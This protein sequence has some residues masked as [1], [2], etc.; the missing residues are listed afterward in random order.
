MY[1]FPQLL[2]KNL[3][4]SLIFI[5]F[6]GGIS[7][8]M[9]SSLLEDKA[10]YHSQMINLLTQKIE[11]TNNDDNTAQN[12]AKTLRK[13]TNYDSLVISNQ[14]GDNL[15]SYINNNKE[16]T[17]PYISPKPKKYIAKQLGVNIFY[18]L[19]FSNEYTLVFNLILF[20]LICSFF[21]VILA[22]KM[23]TKRHEAVFKL[24]NQQIKTDLAL[25]NSTNVPKTEKT[26][27]RKSANPILEIPELKQSLNDI[28]TLISEQLENILNLEKEAY[29][30][31]LT[32]LD[33]RNRFVQFYENQ[34][35]QESTIKFGVLIITRCSELQTINQIHGY[36]EANS[37]ISHVAKLIT[38]A[39]SNYSDAK[40]FRINSSD[41]ASIL[42]NVELTQA[43]TFTKELT[44]VFN[45][46]QQASNFDSIAY[47]GLVHFDKSKPLG[48][49]LA[50]ADT[51]VSV[52]QT[53]SYNAWYSLK[54]TD[55]SQQ[56]SHN[57]GNQNWR[58][59]I[60]S[61]LDNQR[62][63]LLLQPIQPNGRNGKLY[64]EVLARFLNSNNEILPT[65]S[66]IAMAEKL[67]KII[68]IDKLV[69][70]TTMKEIIDK[71]MFD[72][73]FGININARSISDEYFLIWLERKLLREPQ[74]AQRLTFEITE[75]GLQQN[76]KTS[77]RLIEVLHRVGSRI[78]VERFGIGL[79]SFKFFRDLKPDY[80]KMDS[81]YTQ[82]ID[83]DRNN[84]YFL[85]LIVDLAHRLNVNVLT[86]CVERQEEKHTLELLLV[87]GCQGFYIGKPTEL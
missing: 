55:I 86:E 42:P 83:N 27:S 49:L 30:D 4:F 76:I 77:K 22:A 12:I 37:Y 87:D 10:I 7:L 46:Y 71:N 52:A 1:T 51:G 34:V 20:S 21:V 53:Q 5:V 29:I 13:T 38:K 62:I 67:D 56:S 26:N 39:L 48:E 24:I 6:F 85:R 80:I 72:H 79:T 45:E 82:N 41:F 44:R 14:Q 33:N 25:S 61:V 84:Q 75:Y 57:Y 58:Q 47:S 50:L 2:L 19:N 60:E 64:S 66:F 70:E 15:F 65:V 81:S 8:L 54:D 59:E 28:K 78:T 9:L 17:I 74:V 63:K 40:L 68:A 11:S 23:S 32:N 18:Q 31:N 73:N 35:A 16:L 36:K 69:I 3:I 43:E